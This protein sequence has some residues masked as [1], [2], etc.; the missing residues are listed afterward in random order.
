MDSRLGMSL[1]GAGVQAYRE[2][3]EESPES[4]LCDAIQCTPACQ[5]AAVYKKFFCCY[6]RWNRDEKPCTPG[7]SC[8]P[9]VVAHFRC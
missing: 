3:A 2:R 8:S 9:H 7:L 1:L 4:G 6:R 5:S